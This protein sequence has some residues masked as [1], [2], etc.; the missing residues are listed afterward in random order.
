MGAWIRR[1]S[2]PGS[3]RERTTAMAA[4][5]AGAVIAM[6]VLVT[7][8]F[9]DGVA[10]DTTQRSPDCP[11][12]ALRLTRQAPAPAT[13]AAL[14]EASRAYGEIDTDRAR[15]NVAARA[16]SAGARGRTVRR[17]CG[18]RVARRTVVVELFFPEMLPSASL[19]QGTVFVSRFADG[20]HIWFVAH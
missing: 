9:G 17:M 18:G 13:V 1:L 2:R 11:T 8:G 4:F 3:E 20:H 16:A 15:V 5:V 14:A 19:S 12:D 10:H 6:L 7:P